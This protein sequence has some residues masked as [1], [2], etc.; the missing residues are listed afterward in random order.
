VAP[1]QPPLAQ[2]PPPAIIHAWYLP[3]PGPTPPSKTPLL[4]PPRGCSPCRGRDAAT[5]ALVV[6]VCG[7]EAREAAV[8]PAKERYSAAAHVGRWRSR[9]LPPMRLS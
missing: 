7:G 8:A 2:R 4:P 5:V 9:S 6:S 3:P 1:R